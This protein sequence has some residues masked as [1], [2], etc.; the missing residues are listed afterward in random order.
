MIAN[1]S[2][3]GAPVG[4]TGVGVYVPERV[5]TNED[6]ERMLETTYEWNT[7]RTGIWVRRIVGSYVAASGIGVP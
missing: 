3:N 4:I 2:R 1:V 5:L 7:E 6:L